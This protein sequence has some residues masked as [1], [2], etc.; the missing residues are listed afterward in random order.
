MGKDKDS[1]ELRVGHSIGF[2]LSGLRVV[3]HSFP[4]FLLVANVLCGG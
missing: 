4:L 2:E 3:E 1:F